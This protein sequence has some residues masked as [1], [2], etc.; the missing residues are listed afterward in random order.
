[1]DK[2]SFFYYDEIHIPIILLDVLKNIWLVVMAALI[3]CVG[4]FTYANTAYK[5][6]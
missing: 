1:M 3:A 4:V 5:P 6:V 2:K